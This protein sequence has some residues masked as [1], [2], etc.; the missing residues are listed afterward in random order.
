M[1][2][3]SFWARPLGCAVFVAAAF[4]LGSPAR[5]QTALEVY[6]AAIA[7]DAALGTSPAV[8]VVASTSAVTLSGSA[9]SAFDFG[10]TSGDAT[11]EFIVEGDPSV[12][13]SSYLAVGTSNPKSRLVY[14]SW[15]DTGQLGFTQGGV[16]DYLFTPAVL[17]PTTA[18]HVAYVWDPTAQVMKIY[19][20]GGLAG[21]A[22][23]VDASFAMPTGAG[24]LGAA[25][26]TS[27]E[28]MKGTIHRVTVYDEVLTDGMIKR[29]ASAFGAHVS[30]ALAAYDASVTADAGTGLTPTAKQTSTLVFNG[31]GG[32]EFDFG[33]IAD[34]ATLEFILE[35]DPGF[36]NGAYLA[37]GENADSNL[38]YEVWGLP[39]QIGFTQL[40]VADYNFTPGVASPT[41]PTHVAYTWDATARA[42]KIFVNGTLAGSSE[43]IHENFGM[44]TGVGRL[45]ANP[46]NTEQMV[47]TVYR[48]TA[49]D[50]LLSDAAI[51]KHAKAFA[52]LLSPPSITSFTI[53]PEAVTAGSPATLTWEVK[54]ATKVLVDGIDRTGTTNLSVTAPISTVYQIKAE[55]PLGAVTKSV[56]L[57]VN[58]SL[59]GYDAAVASD[60]AAGLKPVTKLTAQVAAI[61]DWGGIPFNFG[62]VTGDATMEFILEGDP[63]TGAGTGIATDFDEAGTWRHS[64]RFSQWDAAGQY[65]F[66]KRAVAD[67]AFPQPVPTA[68]WPTHVAY[69]WDATALT[70]KIY[71]NGTLAGTKTEVSADFGLPTGQGVLGEG[72]VGTIFR[73]T[74]YSGQ[75]PE[76][77]IASHAR[78]FLSEAR[79]QLLAYDTAINQSSAAG[80]TPTSRLL[81]P[82]TLPGDRGISFSYGTVSGDGTLEFVLEGDP[83]ASI[84]SILAMS[85]DNTTSRLVFESWPN[86]GQLGFTQGGVADYLFTPA[87]PTPTSV[88]HV[89]YVWSATTATMKLYLNGTLAG[90]TSG[91]DAA[92]ALPNEI[93][94]LGSAVG[95]GEPM[96]GT[97]HRVTVYDDLLSEAV[98][99]AHAS[100]FASAPKPPKLALEFGINPTLVLTEGTAGAHYR[101]EY[102][103][104]LGA[105]EAWVSLQDI[106]SLS[107]TSARVTDSTPFAGHAQRFYRAVLVP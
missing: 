61:G 102:K 56:R 18:T 38:R 12:G 100:V 53:S 83:S 57:Q 65:G 97:I 7:A 73:V 81:A 2:R 78:A 84:S 107:G 75:V 77:K 63:T 17:S 92:F 59:S 99:Q 45:G 19:L 101:I 62:E 20:N 79:P 26:S 87:V 1:T 54:N 37:V 46:S 33:A 69:V 36:G 23:N 68:S 88:T 27:D 76:T 80:L 50:S 34:D 39:N 43:G 74:V 70:V 95:G 11:M 64:L 21:S 93:G 106:P 16:A 98:L 6:D 60:D 5:A 13:V 91:V 82:V 89:A 8:P 25:G 4:A 14:E 3:A 35:G 31:A 29:H 103:A 55:N 48:V 66:T 28:A 44:P 24:W 71:V 9:G 96:K 40:R 90:T 49:Y 85:T 104:S 67:Y 105:T 32:T 10:A 94:S 42:M 15:S 22:T 52:D 41:L 72:M 30:K 58:P 86:S 47:G 51:Q